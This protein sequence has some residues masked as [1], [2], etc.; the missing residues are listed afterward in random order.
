M[1]AGAADGPPSDFREGRLKGLGALTRVA[2]FIRLV[3]PLRC[4][5]ANERRLR[6]SEQTET[7]AAAGTPAGVLGGGSVR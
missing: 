1:L 7:F 3:M 2:V 4:G 6:R 5:R